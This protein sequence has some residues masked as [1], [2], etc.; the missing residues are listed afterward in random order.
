[1][2]GLRVKSNRSTPAS[3]PFRVSLSTTISMVAVIF[4]LMHSDYGGGSATAQEFVYP[5]QAKSERDL[6]TCAPYEICSVVHKRYWFSIK[7]ERLC[8]CDVDGQECPN[9]WSDDNDENGEPDKYT[10]AL[11]NRAQIKF[12]EPITALPNCLQQQSPAEDE[13]SINTTTSST[14]APV[15]VE[16]F[17]HVINETRTETSSIDNATTKNY[18]LTSKAECYCPPHNTWIAHTHRKNQTSAAVSHSSTSYRC[19]RLPKCKAG[20]TCGYERI[21]L[22][23]NY[24]K[25]SCPYGYL[26]LRSDQ[27]TGAS[28]A[29]DTDTRPVNEMLYQ[30]PAFLTYCRK[31]YD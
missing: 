23:S 26:C 27:S 25:C 10:M 12:C 29:L 19:S 4:T 9:S 17:L 7:V 16:R 5:G 22:Y 28:A 31:R 14:A 2:S 8:R 6:S 24:Y 3:A 20:D 11:N 1:M 13:N 21:D 15:P 30:G 18:K